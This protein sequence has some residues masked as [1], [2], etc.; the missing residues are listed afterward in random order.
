MVMEFLS[1]NIKDAIG[2]INDIA[3]EHLSLLCKENGYIEN[4][5]Y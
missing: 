5:D 2:I 1:K 4:K 3:P